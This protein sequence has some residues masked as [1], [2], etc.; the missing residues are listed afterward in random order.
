M[1]TLCRPSTS[2]GHIHALQVQTN[3]VDEISS[4]T[5]KTLLKNSKNSKKLISQHLLIYYETLNGLLCEA[6]LLHLK[7]AL[8]V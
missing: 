2:F 6:A 5:L 4:T 8:Y 1:H 3:T 7:Q